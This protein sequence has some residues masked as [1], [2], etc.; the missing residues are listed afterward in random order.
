MPSHL[1]LYPVFDHREASIRMTYSEIV[2]PAA[3]DRIDLLDHLPHRLADVSSED[4]PELGKQRGPLLQLRRVIWPPHLGT[5]QNATVLKAEKREA[6]FLRQV[7]HPALI[8]IDLHSELCQ[9]L[10][11]SPFHR[12]HQPV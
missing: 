2:H 10:P 7:H 3:Q 4:F 12:P 11:Q 6:L 8:F 5:T 1:L 9:L